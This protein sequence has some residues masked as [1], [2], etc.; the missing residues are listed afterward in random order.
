MN[1]SP[2]SNGEFY[3]GTELML[4]RPGMNRRWLR[5]R[6]VRRSLLRTMIAAALASVEL[7][8]LTAHDDPTGVGWALLTFVAIVTVAS[9]VG[10]AVDY[11]CA[12]YDHQHRPDK[13]CF[14]EVVPGKYFY[15]ASDFH[16]YPPSTVESVHRIITVVR[17]VHTSPAAGWLASRHLRE[18][19]Q[20]AWEALRT[21][22]AS[23]PLRS[24]IAS[25]HGEALA[26]PRPAD[27][28]GLANDLK[29][30]RSCVAAVDNAVDQIMTYLLQTELLVTSWEQKLADVEVRARLRTTLDWIPQNAGAITLHRAETV[31]ESIFAC[32]TA[33]RD[34]TDAG[35]FVWEGPR[36]D[37]AHGVATQSRQ[38]PNGGA[39]P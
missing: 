12:E 18:V 28:D 21:L 23:R 33:A 6:T 5:W 3:S 17:T 16:G 32:I 11:H 25:A 27:V 36:A 29:A 30:A 31:T 39:R 22:D 1:Q 37:D 19:H 4:W 7:A 26:G 34:L 14:L 20:V 13:P 15:R 24:T 38:L 35:R 8:M 10:V 2:V 9:G